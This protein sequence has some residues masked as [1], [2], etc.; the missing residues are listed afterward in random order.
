MLLS[1][2][3]LLL[4][5]S[6]VM[7]GPLHKPRSLDS[8]NANPANNAS[9]Q[10]TIIQDSLPTNNPLIIATGI[11]SKI[12]EPVL[13]EQ[14]GTVGVG[15]NSTEVGLI[16]NPSWTNATIIISEALNRLP[17]DDE[18]PYALVILQTLQ[19]STISMLDTYSV[20]DYAPP[21]CGDDPIRFLPP[22]AQ[23]IFGDQAQPFELSNTPQFTSAK[24]LS[25]ASSMNISATLLLLPDPDTIPPPPDTLLPIGNT[26]LPDVPWNVALNNISEALLFKAIGETPPAQPTD[27]DNNSITSRALLRLRGLAKRETV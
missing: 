12:L 27:S 18:L 2:A 10:V 1:V 14:T 15:A 11:T 9:V 7:A 6:H 19:P 22:S 16:F 8:N 4:L 24:F 20:T 23:T 13:G 5:S 26:T 21:P 3:S 17:L 25:V